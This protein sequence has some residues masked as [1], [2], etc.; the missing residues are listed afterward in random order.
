MIG[1]EVKERGAVSELVEPVSEVRLEGVGVEAMALPEG[2]VGVL[3][4][5]VREG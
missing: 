4:G 5:E 1:R 2:K 3:E